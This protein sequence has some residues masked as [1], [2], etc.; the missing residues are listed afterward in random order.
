MHAILGPLGVRES[1][2]RLIAADLRRME[3]EVMQLEHDRVPVPAAIGSGERDYGSQAVS[4]IDRQGLGQQGRPDIKAKNRSSLVKAKEAVLGSR[5]KC[6]DMGLTAFLLK[7]GEGMGELIHTC[8]LPGIQIGHRSVAD[9]SR[10]S[11]PV[12]LLFGAFKT[13]F[14]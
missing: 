3:D 5:I 2:S 11:A 9:K 1:L 4:G 10:R 14:T 8:F 7:Y 13:Y 12:L 6:P